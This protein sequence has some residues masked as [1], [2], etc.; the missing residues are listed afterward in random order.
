MIRRP[1]RDIGR[2]KATR[3]CNDRV[4]IVCEGRKTEP[5]Y[6]RGLKN[7][8]RLTMVEVIGQGEDPEGVVREAKRKRKQ[9]S[10]SYEK[11]YCVFDR[12]KHENFDRACNKA[13]HANMIPIRSW[14]C[15]E[16]WLLLHFRFS[17]RPYDESGGNSTGQNCYNEL[18]NLWK[19]TYSST[20][21]KAMPG[22]FKRLKERLARAQDN[23]IRAL[24]DA[25]TTKQ[26]NPPTE[27]HKLV[28][29]LQTIEQ[30]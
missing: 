30:S 16:F 17:R 24:A 11:I 25:E 5:Q 23:A 21:K 2:K 29:Y 15:F 13:T 28:S 22:T 9:E 14:P 8:Y 7:H 12:D 3:N 26:W 19:E 27:V 6:F 20:Y 18:N 1:R 4:L 10:G